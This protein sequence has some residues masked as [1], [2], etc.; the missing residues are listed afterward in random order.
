MKEK[1]SYIDLA[2]GYIENAKGVEDY[3]SAFKYA[4]IAAKRGSI[5][6]HYILG[7]LYLYGT[8]CNKNF[9]RAKKHFSTFILKCNENDNIEQSVI[10]DAYYKLAETEKKLKHYSNAYLCYQKLVRINPQYK[11]ISQNFALDLKESRRDNI[12]NYLV[13]AGS[14]IAV[15]ICFFATC[16]MIKTYVTDYS[17]KYVIEPKVI[18][19]EKVP[20]VASLPEKVEIKDAVS[21]RIVSEEDFNKLNLK[22]IEIADIVASSEYISKTGNNYGAG[23]LV[24]GNVDTVW[25][26]GEE[27]AGIEQS[28]IATFVEPSI[29]S[30]IRIVNGKQKSSDDYFA[31]NRMASFSIFGEEDVVVELQ[32][33]CAPQYVVFNNPVFDS[34]VQLVIKSVFSGTVYNDTCITDIDFFE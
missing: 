13:A 7:Q 16:S 33:L 23:N 10:E 30:G 1:M 11:E 28:I 32:D 18:R 6:A 20:A 34:Q 8:G 4:R 22:K 27:D 2:N 24:D 26:E 19:E 3:C 9:H 29:I 21:Y 31:N 12:C 15:C 17:D 5:E 25:Q 14:L